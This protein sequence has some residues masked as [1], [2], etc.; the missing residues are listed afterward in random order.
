MADLQVGLMSKSLS[1]S[2][3]M[4]VLLHLNF[5]YDLLYTPA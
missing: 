4:S 5:M 1:A 2:E 3:G